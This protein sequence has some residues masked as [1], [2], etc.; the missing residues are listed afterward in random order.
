MATAVSS[1][2]AAVGGTSLLARR[3]RWENATSV[4]LMGAAVLQLV[5]YVWSAGLG[6][7]YEQLNYLDYFVWALFVTDYAVRL[8]FSRGCGKRV[9]RDHPLDLLAGAVPSIP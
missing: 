2:N 6:A 7:Q 4:P 3:K 8:Y 9:F 1:D 5:S